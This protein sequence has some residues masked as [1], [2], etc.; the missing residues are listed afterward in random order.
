MTMGAE[1]CQSHRSPDWKEAPKSES[2][3]KKIAWRQNCQTLQ[4]CKKMI[5]WYLKYK[6]NN[7]VIFVQKSELGITATEKNLAVSNG[8]K[9]GVGL[10]E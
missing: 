9:I 7:S 5:L 8:Q 6:K 4:K 1:S 3:L 2:Y 10:F